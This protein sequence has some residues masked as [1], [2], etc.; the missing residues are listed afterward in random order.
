MLVVIDTI[1]QLIS[2]MKKF[3]LIKSDIEDDFDR[4]KQAFFTKDTRFKEELLQSYIVD[5]LL[6][7]SVKQ[8]KDLTT[9]LRKEL[10]NTNVIK[11]LLE[12]FI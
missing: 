6:D 11:C 10:R 5:R 1:N 7:T 4:L 9:F 3:R 2:F 12:Q 8:L